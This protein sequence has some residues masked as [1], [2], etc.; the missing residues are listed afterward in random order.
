LPPRI[1]SALVFMFAA[2]ITTV[3]WLDF[4]GWVYACGCRSLWAGGAVNCNIHIP[5]MRHCPWCSSG[6]TGYRIALM[7]VIV[8]Q[9]VIALCSAGWHIAVRFAVTFAAFP[10]VGGMVAGIYGLLYGYW[11]S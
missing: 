2:G 5:N 7:C 11:G 4:C 8:P 6:V 3:F 10:L 9:L 1:Q